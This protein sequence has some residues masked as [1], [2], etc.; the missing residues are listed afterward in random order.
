MENIKKEK[1]KLWILSLVHPNHTK[2][3]FRHRRMQEIQAL[4][5]KIRKAKTDKFY[6]AKM[7]D[8]ASTQKNL[9]S[10]HR[11][12]GTQTILNH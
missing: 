10:Y 9:Y 2:H 3:I 8:T 4:I 7:Y 11:T 12:A 1:L 5:K 6:I